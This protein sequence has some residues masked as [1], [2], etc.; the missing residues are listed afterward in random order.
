MTGF[1]YN[2]DRKSSYSKKGAALVEKENSVDY[3]NVNVCC[4][5][6]FN[7]NHFCR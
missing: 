1:C 3:I 2:N 7:T 4:S 5:S 6:I